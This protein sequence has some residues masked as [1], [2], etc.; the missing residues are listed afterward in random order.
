MHAR[1]SRSSLVR[2]LAVLSAL[3]LLAM[4]C[5]DDDGGGDQSGGDGG[6]D[7]GGE[8]A[9]GCEEGDEINLGLISSPSSTAL[10]AAI[11]DFEEA[12]GATATFTET[13]YAEAHQKYLLNFEAKNGE[14]DV[15]QFD[16]NF[17]GSFG[18]REVMA[19]LDDY[20]AASDAYDIDDFSKPLQEYGKFDDTTYGLILSTE[21]MILWYRTDIYD[22]LDLQ[23]ATTW[24]EYLA[25]AQAVDES[26]LGAGNALGYGSSSAWWFLQLLWS[27]GGDI[28]TDDLEPT[29][30]TPEAVEAMEFFKETLQYA[31]DGALSYNGDDVTINFGSSDIGEMVQYS[32]YYPLVADPDQSQIADKFGVARVPVGDADVIHLA[33]WT[34]GIPA[35]APNKDCAWVFLEMALGKDNAANFLESGAAAIGRTSI[36]TDPAML[37]KF[38]YLELL[39]FPDD[40]RLERYPQYVGYQE[41]EP[42]ISQRVSDILSGQTSVEEG[43]DKMQG[44]LEPIFEQERSL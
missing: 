44:D 22:E 20:L 5:G 37:E 30:N 8:V 31:P 7:G 41:M 27:F 34:I 36:I 23:P 17:L 32:G 14:F 11:P 38:P 24:D 40:Q 19:P 29:V 10:Q 25:N 12:T 9:G 42:K 6:G 33:G 35:D 21:P 16:N 28:A 13:P 18:K 39:S 4:A 3:S 2:L 26:G 1:R 43:L 15:A